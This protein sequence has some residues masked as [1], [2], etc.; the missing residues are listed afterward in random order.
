MAINHTVV[1]VCEEDN[2]YSQKYLYTSTCID[3][4]WVDWMIFYVSF[5]VLAKI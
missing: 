3:E 1:V 4:F 2:E 5:G